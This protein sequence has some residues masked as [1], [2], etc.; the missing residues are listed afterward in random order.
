MLASCGSGLSLSQGPIA[1]NALERTR[2]ERKCQ[3]PRISNASLNADVRSMRS[4]VVAALAA[5]VVQP[6]VFSTWFF[7]PLLLGGAVV[8][9]FDLL[10]PSTFVLVFA[11]GFVIVLGVPIFLLL[12]HL[13]HAR[14]GPVSLSGLLVGAIP[15]AIYSWP[16]R[17]TC[18]G[19]FHSGTWHGSHVD[20]EVN[21]VPTLYGWLRYLEGVLVWGVHGLIGAFIFFLVWRR[22]HGR[23]NALEQ[24]A[25]PSASTR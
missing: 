5:I 6:F 18:A 22:M 16:L 7:A 2:G 3:H 25:R 21:G 8:S 14:V 13:G 9:A 10:Q 17:F 19:C 24:N 12:R 1:N 15:I 11:A 4:V 20:F 23:N